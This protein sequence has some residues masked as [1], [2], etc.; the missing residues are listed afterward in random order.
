MMRATL[1]SR[2]AATASVAAAFLLAM[3]GVGQAAVSVSD[4]DHGVTATDLANSIVGGGVSISN[5]TYTGDDRG[6]GTFS[7]GA[8]SIGFDSGAVLD[9]GKVQTVAGDTTCSGGVEGPNDCH[10]PPVDNSN[11]TDFGT[12]GDADLTALSGQNTGDAAVLEFDFVPAASTVEF[13][14]VFSSEEYNTYANTNFNDVFGF[15]INETN[16]ALVP[17][18]SDPVTINTINNGNPGGDTTPHHP[19]LFR[20]NVRPSPTIDTQMDGLTV[21]LTCTAPVDAGQT[22]H[23][24]LAIADA[25]DTALDSA[26]FLQGGSFVSTEGKISARGTVLTAQGP[27]IGFSAANDCTPSLS[28]RPS[29]V[30]TATGARIWTKSTVTASDCTD[31]P[32][33]STLGFDTQTGTATGTFGPAAPGGRN[34]QTGTLQWTYYDNSPDTVQFTLKDSSNTVVFQAASQTPT[35]FRGSPGGVWTFGP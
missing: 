9:S 14:Y 30:G 13:S 17:S 32:P 2:V 5:V 10:E 33:T 20:D 16:C 24:K 29:I 25:S 4:L 21:V 27:S 31:Q 3:A 26:V 15:F 1:I 6:A 18:T 35:A 34:G 7:G 22:N 23:M 19:E 11:S 28:T 12:P 8:P